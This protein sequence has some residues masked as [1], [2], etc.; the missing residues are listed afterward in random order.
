MEILNLALAAIISLAGLPAGLLVAK[1]T[2]EELNPGKRYFMW[3]QNLLLIAAIIAFFY[4]NNLGIT[5][6]VIL[7]ILASILIIKS[8]PR[9]I[10]S[11]IIFFVLIAFSFKKIE[12]L[13]ILFSSVFM[14][15][16]P[17]GALITSKG[18]ANYMKE[19]LENPINPSYRK[20]LTQK[21]IYVAW[22]IMLEI[23]SIPAYFMKKK[24]CAEYHLKFVCPLCP[25]SRKKHRD[26][27][28]E[29]TCWWEYNWRKGNYNIPKHFGIMN[30][31]RQYM[32][33]GTNL[34]KF[35]EYDK[36]R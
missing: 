1:F 11:Y 31:I 9:A 32:M 24:S 21:I 29:S 23:K 6:F 7:A 4:Y 5:I 26:V 27:H 36:K 19:E 35:K 18:L 10:T 14:Y 30:W 15:G 2:K 12:L 13:T 16:L 8:N 17:T 28:G 3:M 20:K 33:L 34:K 25:S 22:V